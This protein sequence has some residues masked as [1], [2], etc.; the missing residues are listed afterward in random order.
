MKKILIKNGY[1]ISMNKNREIFNHGSILIEGGIIKALGKISEKDISEET[2]VYDA[3]GKIILPGF[4]NTHVHLSQQL[5]RGVADDV[6]LLTW[7]RERVWPYESSFDSEDSYISSLACCVEL[8]KSGTTTFLEA[9]GQ[10]VESMVKAVGESAAAY[11][12]SP[13]NFEKTPAFTSSV[14]K[15]LYAA[16]LGAEGCVANVEKNEAVCAV[17]PMI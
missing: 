12:Y 13:S 11:T 8:I 1:I 9:G 10:F 5:G 15:E 16:A 3:N 2:E 4:V 14:I 17:N 7:L 6:D